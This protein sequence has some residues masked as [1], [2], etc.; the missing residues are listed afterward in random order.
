MKYIIIVTFVLLQFALIPAHG[1]YYDNVPLNF[2]WSGAPL[3]CVWDSDYNKNAKEA[4]SNWQQALV[5]NYGES[6]YFPA[7][8]ILP[9]TP[10]EHIKNCKINIIYV[11]E[12]YAT[13]EGLTDENGFVKGGIMLHKKNLDMMWIIVY[14]AK[15]AVFLTLQDFDDMMTTTTMHE[16]GHSFGIGHVV[17]ENMQEKLKPWP[18]TVMW[19]F[20]GHET[21]KTLYPQDLE[22]F[23]CLYPGHSWLGSN[24]IH[25]PTHS[26]E[27]PQRPN[28]FTGEVGLSMDLQ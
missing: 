9:D 15:G 24:P 22:A 14:E 13:L 1:Y 19:P 10:S 18:N 28:P 6:F 4:I 23:R 2:T 5:D 20:S 25:C 12:E 27:F 7:I 21:H 3:I 8:L 16:I 11:E 26:V 17:S